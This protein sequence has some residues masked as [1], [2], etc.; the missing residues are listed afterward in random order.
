MG[1][2][3]WENIKA[4]KLKRKKCLFKNE[5]ITQIYCGCFKIRVVSFEHLKNEEDHVEKCEELS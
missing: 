2:T 4:S 3:I 5:S 1:L